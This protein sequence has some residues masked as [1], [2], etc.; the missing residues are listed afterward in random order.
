[1]KKL[2]AVFTAV[3]FLVLPLCSCSNGDVPQGM[4]LA[5][6]EGEPFKLFVP[7][8]MN[9]NTESGISGAFLHTA[10]KHK[11]IVSARYYTPSDVNM[12]LDSY[13][14]Y[15]KTEYAKSLAEF[16]VL[17]QD[18]TVLAEKDAVKLVYTAR[19]EDV[20]YTCTQY[21]VLH[22][23]DMVS[24]H[25]YFPTDVISNYTDVM[26]SVVD[27]FTLC[28]KAEVKNNEFVDKN[29]PDGMKIAS[30]DKIEYRFYVPKNWI[31]DSESG[32]SEA[33]YPESEKSNVTVTAYSP[34]DT[35]TA[36]EYV[37][38]CEGKYVTDIMGYTLIEKKVDLKVA[39]RDAISLTF[40]ATY[41]GVEFKIRQMFFEYGQRIYTITYTAVKSNFDLHTA[42]VDKMIS[43]FTFR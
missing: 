22:N 40:G 39:G 9:L 6:V 3:I 5:S 14:E 7:E 19:I 26:S 12:S 24:L 37:A 2:I 43:E 30:H 15:C 1:M 42:D 13:V 35:L 32:V 38:L 33:Y 8:G 34:D 18:P 41:D 20:N 4:Q 21:S 31:C 23:G 28:D 16:N 11:I 17:Q 36:A 25:F 29:T 27:E 10:D